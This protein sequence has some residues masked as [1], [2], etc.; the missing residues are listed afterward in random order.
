[1]DRGLPLSIFTNSWFGTAPSML[2][3]QTSTST[4]MQLAEIVCYIHTLNQMPWNWIKGIIFKI[5][6][7][8]FWLTYLVAFL[9]SL[10]SVSCC[11]VQLELLP[12]SEFQPCQPGSDCTVN[13]VFCSWCWDMADWTWT[14]TLAF[15]SQS[16]PARWC[17]TVVRVVR[18]SIGNANWGCSCW[19]TP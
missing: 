11:Q 7:H 5:A 1:M 18:I 3:C 17:R 6:L 10:L 19:E 16:T 2:I 12:M 8:C 15:L 4:W 14:W 9:C 13:Q